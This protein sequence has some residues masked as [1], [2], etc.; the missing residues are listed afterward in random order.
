M[1]WIGLILAASCAA[2][3]LV[4]WRFVRA[5]AVNH[6]RCPFKVGVDRIDCVRP[7]ESD[8]PCRHL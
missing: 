1:G 7:C 3:L 5:S 4:V 6:D 2:V 8:P